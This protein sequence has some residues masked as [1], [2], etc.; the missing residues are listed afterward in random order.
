MTQRPRLNAGLIPEDKQIIRRHVHIYHRPH[1]IPHRNQPT[2]QQKT[3]D[4][5]EVVAWQADGS[6]KEH[7]LLLPITPQAIHPKNPA[8]TW[9]DVRRPLKIASVS[10]DKQMPTGA[11]A[12]PMPRRLSSSVCSSAPK[13]HIV[14]PK[15]V[16]FG[17]PS[18]LAALLLL[19]FFVF[20]ARTGHT[21]QAAPVKET[22]NMSKGGVV[23]MQNLVSAM[24]NRGLPD[25]LEIPKIKVNAHILYMGIRADGHMAAP[26]DIAHVGWY[27]YGPLPGNAGSAVIVGHLDG[28]KGQPG[29]FGSLGK[30]LPGDAV[31]VVDDKHQTTSFVVRAVQTYNQND[32][33]K[34]LFSSSG[35][36]LN[37]V[38]C[39]G[40]WDPVHHSYLQRLVVFTDKI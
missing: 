18:A 6:A 14:T 36:H 39:T 8:Y 5:S 28:L 26:G 20:G 1:A 40:S 15:W 17:A 22:A 34:D 38:T 25:Q 24:P 9:S 16:L 33:P 7:S 10:G 4:C 35:S 30:L 32:S 19:S 2:T 29:V 37:L 21:M 27:K 23:P 13:S 3:E 31:S 11:A 12:Q